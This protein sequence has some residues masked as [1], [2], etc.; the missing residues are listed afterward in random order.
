[1]RAT[2]RPSFKNLRST[3]FL[4]SRVGRANQR[5]NTRPEL[6]LRRALWRLG[7]RYR[8]H[9][10]NLPGSPDIILTRYRTV[11]FVDGDFWH[12]RNWAKRRVLLSRGANSKYWISKIE[13]N[14][15]RDRAVRQSLRRQG[16]RVIRVWESSIRKDCS[17]VALLVASSLDSE[18]GW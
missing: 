8:I 5:K 1:M 10:R 11:I 3:S 6:L 17:S 2:R 16:W 12:G 18:T 7:Y 9:S 4:A 13:S 14:R 15:Q